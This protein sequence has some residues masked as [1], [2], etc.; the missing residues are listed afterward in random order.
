MVKSTTGGRRCS[1]TA[2]TVPRRATY[3][4]EKI[5]MHQASST[6]KLANSTGGVSP[7]AEGTWKI[8]SE[9]KMKPT[10][11]TMMTSI[12]PKASQSEN[13]EDVGSSQVKKSCSHQLRRSDAASSSSTSKKRSREMGVSSGLSGSSKRSINKSTCSSI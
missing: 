12:T 6:C 1:R 13:I 10:E 5:I 7:S 2:P 4:T 9:E 8:G 11:E 3:S